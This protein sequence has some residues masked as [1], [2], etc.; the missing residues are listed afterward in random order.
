M[1]RCSAVADTIVPLR[2]RHGLGVGISDITAPGQPTRFVGKQCVAGIHVGDV[3]MGFYFDED[4]I[5]SSADGEKVVY[6]VQKSPEVS[7]IKFRL[8][9][10]PGCR[11]TEFHSYTI[12]PE[13]RGRKIPENH[14]HFECR[15]PYKPGEWKDV[16]NRLMAALEG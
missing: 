9:R 10:V 1:Q 14:V 2:L 8:N 3:H 11:F 5:V 16:L 4:G 13:E 15:G 6:N 7:N 12:D